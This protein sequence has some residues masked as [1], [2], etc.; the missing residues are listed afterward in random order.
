MP[1]VKNP[2]ATFKVDAW[3]D[4]E[5]EGLVTVEFDDENTDS[6]IWIYVDGKRFGSLYFSRHP[7][8]AVSITLGQLVEPHGE[9]DEVNPVFAEKENY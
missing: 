5:L 1:T 2:P 6:N 9:W 4:S 8:G 7:D 3:G